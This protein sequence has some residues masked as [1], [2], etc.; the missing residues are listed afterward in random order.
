MTSHGKSI[1]ETPETGEITV[2]RMVTA[3]SALAAAGLH[4]PKHNGKLSELTA[5]YQH[6]TAETIWEDMPER[7]YLLIQCRFGVLAVN[8]DSC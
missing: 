4:K 6:S 2:F 5:N 7:S 1:R 8:R 3:L